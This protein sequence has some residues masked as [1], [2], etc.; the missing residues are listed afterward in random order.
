MLEKGNEMT[1]N[2]IEEDTSSLSFIHFLATKV[3]DMGHSHLKQ[4]LT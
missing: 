1:V 2:K 3:L 4:N